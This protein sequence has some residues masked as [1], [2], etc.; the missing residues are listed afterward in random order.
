[1]KRLFIVRGKSSN[2]PVFEVHGIQDGLGIVGRYR[3]L[4]C[5]G[6]AYN[7]IWHDKKGRFYSK[8]YHIFDLGPIDN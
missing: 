4:S 2:M 7:G 5:D 3:V 1:M 6:E 8:D